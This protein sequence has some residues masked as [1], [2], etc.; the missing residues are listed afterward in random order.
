VVDKK[1]SLVGT[2]TEHLERIVFV[3]AEEALWAGDR[4]AADTLKNMVTSELMPMHPKFRKERDVR[5]YLNFMFCSNH[6]HAVQA[7]IR[8][9]RFFVLDVDD[10][11]AGDEHRD[12]WDAVYDD[13]KCN[14][15][16]GYRQFLA[17]LLSIDL[18]DWHPRK[19]VRTE[20]ANRQV[21]QSAD[22][23]IQWW[24]MSIQ[25]GVVAACK[26]LGANNM[27]EDGKLDA[28]HE[29]SELRK[30]YENFCKSNSLRPSGDDFFKR[31]AWVCGP[32]KRSSLPSRPWGYKVP[33]EDTIR[34]KID[35][36]LLS[37]D[38]PES[39]PAAKGKK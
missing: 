15:G 39:K 30:A 33:D 20:A 32:R 14:G 36:M 3:Q 2:F 10:A 19:L 29:T 21:R 1:G 13:L 12:Y 5:N 16:E 22:S 34:E 37:K 24:Q 7:G 11:K 26:Y 4:Q 17:F 9:R 8:D 23:V 28:W 27:I 31:L 6:E 35:E 18:T 25:L 38:K